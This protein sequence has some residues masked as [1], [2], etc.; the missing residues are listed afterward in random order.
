MLGTVPAAEPGIAA[1]LA[2]FASPG[3]LAPPGPSAG[4]SRA[5]S[6]LARSD[7]PQAAAVASLA[8]P[9]RGLQAAPALLPR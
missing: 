7:T 1:L 2:R 4:P 9:Q 6:G 5:P 3:S 8:P